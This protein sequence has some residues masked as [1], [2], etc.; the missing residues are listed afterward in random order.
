VGNHRHYQC[1]CYITKLRRKNTQIII[2]D[3]LHKLLFGFALRL[4]ISEVLYE[5]REG[6][7]ACACAEIRKKSLC[8]RDL[9]QS[10]NA[11]SSHICSL[12]D[13]CC[14][15][16]LS[17]F[18]APNYPF[19]RSLQAHNEIKHFLKK[20]A[21]F[22]I[23][24]PL[25]TRVMFSKS[26]RNNNNFFKWKKRVQQPQSEEYFRIST[27]VSTSM[28]SP[29]ESFKVILCFKLGSIF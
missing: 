16:L 3:H 24:W 18:I 13:I 19:W 10:V 4:L 15:I 21:K 25:P 9:Q 14:Q 17:H 20:S 23:N 7:H 26:C 27:I 28:L 11:V 22:F 6:M 2:H 1:H 5:I 8:S 29:P 12:D